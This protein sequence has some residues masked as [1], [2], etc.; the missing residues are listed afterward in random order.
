MPCGLRPL[1]V[2]LA[3]LPPGGTRGGPTPPAQEQG[4]VGSLLAFCRRRMDEGLL[5]RAGARSGG[6]R[7]P[8]D[9]PLQPTKEFFRTS[10]SSTCSGWRTSRRNSAITGW[11][12]SSARPTE[13]LPGCTDGSLQRKRLP[14]FPPPASQQ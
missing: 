6:G 11:K 8:H 7:I 5:L 3:P 12:H 10:Y 9:C 1:T 4:A 2:P 13:R 14:P